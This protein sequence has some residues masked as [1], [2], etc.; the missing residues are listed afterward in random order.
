LKIILLVFPALKKPTLDPN[1][2]KNYRPFSNLSFLSKTL[3][4]LVSNQI[5]DYQ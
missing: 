2:F 4:R 5:L 3:L 1:L